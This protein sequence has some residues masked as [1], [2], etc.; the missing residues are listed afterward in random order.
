MADGTV[1][2]EPAPASA[3]AGSG[4]NR[5][6]TDYIAGELRERIL[7]RRLPPGEP[8][9]QEKIAGE[10]GTSR[11][12]VRE[13]LRRLESEGLVVIRPY[14]GARVAELDIVECSEIYKIRER[15]EPLALSESMPH[16]TDQQRAEVQ[17]LAESLPAKR[18]DGAAWLDGDRS[19][20]LATYLAVPSPR[21]LRMIVGYWNTTQHYRRLLLSTFSEHDFEMVDC[22]HRLIV[23][24]V[25]TRNA[26]LGEEVLR[27]HIERSRT[28][29]T[30]SDLFLR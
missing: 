21:L 10:L 13:A 8:L 25:L 12:P 2:R 19:F 29:L 23:D 28:R 26:R 1:S 30:E 27:L 18:G 4:D 15:L 16:L 22:E 14:S 9:R 3:A 11:I 6:L 20:H 17:R 24:A 7:Q 5:S